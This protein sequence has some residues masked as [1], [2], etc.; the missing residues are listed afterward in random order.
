MNDVINL[1]RERK[2]RKADEDAKKAETNRVL[3][4]RTKAQRL[5]DEAE[6]SRV[7]GLLDGKKLDDKKISLGQGESS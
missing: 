4:G 5:S 1:R 2:R 6:K 3:F 7:S